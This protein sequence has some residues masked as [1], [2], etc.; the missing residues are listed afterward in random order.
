MLRSLRDGRFENQLLNVGFR[1]RIEVTLAFEHIIDNLELLLS[2]FI[3][4]I[5]F[6]NQYVYMQK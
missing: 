2:K 4:K 3:T 5:H 6:F 1:G